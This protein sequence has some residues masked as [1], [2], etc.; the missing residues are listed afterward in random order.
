M[1]L[2]AAPLRMAIMPPPGIASATPVHVVQQSPVQE[3][4]PGWIY[5]PPQAPQPAESTRY[6][7]ESATYP[8]AY[9]TNYVV[10]KVT[11][12][13]GQVPQPTYYGL[14]D[15]DRMRH[16]LGGQSGTPTEDRRMARIL[17]LPRGEVRDK[18]M[19]GLIEAHVESNRRNTNPPFS[20]RNLNEREG[21]TLIPRNGT[22]CT[23][24][25]I[26]IDTGCAAPAIITASLMRRMGLEPALQR[27]SA[28]YSAL[29]NSGEF[30][31]ELPAGELMLALALG[32]PG[33][34]KLH[35]AWLVIESNT[36]TY[37]CLIGTPVITSLNLRVGPWEQL[38]FYQRHPWD[39][40][41]YHVPVITTLAPGRL[42][43]VLHLTATPTTDFEVYSVVMAGAAIGEARTPDVVVVSP[44][45]AMDGPYHPTWYPEGE[46]TE[47]W[48]DIPLLVEGADGEHVS[49]LT[50]LT[51]GLRA[52]T[53]QP[54]GLPGT[55]LTAAQQAVAD[56]AA[57]QTV[58]ELYAEDRVVP[59]PLPFDMYA[60]YMRG[61]EGEG[62]ALAMHMPVG[63]GPWETCDAEVPIVVTTPG[64][65]G[66]VIMGGT[67]LRLAASVLV[68]Q[69]DTGGTST[70]AQ[71][72]VGHPPAEVCPPLESAYWAMRRITAPDSQRSAEQQ[73]RNVEMQ[74]AQFAAYEQM[75]EE[76][77]DPDTRA[78][79]AEEQHMRQAE[80]P[81]SWEHTWL[82]REAEAKQLAAVLPAGD[83]EYIKSRKQLQDKAGEGNGNWD[84]ED[85]FMVHERAWV[86]KQHPEVSSPMVHSVAEYRY[87]S[88]IG[89]YSIRSS[90]AA[91]MGHEAKGAGPSE[92]HEQGSGGTV[93]ETPEAER[94]GSGSSSELE[95]SPSAEERAHRLRVVWDM[96]K[97]DEEKRAM[98]DA[99]DRTRERAGECAFG[100]SSPGA[101]IAQGC[102]WEIAKRQVLQEQPDLEQ[103]AA[104]EKTAIMGRVRAMLDAGVPGDRFLGWHNGKELQEVRY[105]VPGLKGKQLVRAGACWILSRQRTRDELEA[106]EYF[107]TAWAKL[108]ATRKQ[109][110]AAGPSSPSTVEPGGHQAPAVSRTPAADSQQHVQ[111][112][113]QHRPAGL[114]QQPEK[115]TA[116]QRTAGQEAES[117]RQP[118]AAEHTASAWRGPENQAWR[119]RNHAAADQ[120][121]T[122]QQKT[123]LE[124]C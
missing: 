89:G 58:A 35:V 62:A 70:A 29:A 86:R 109:R 83:A 44:V 76:G 67:Q 32:A 104:A 28:R 23:P 112:P 33:Q 20:F 101:R 46:E 21:C 66:E 77:D 116:K 96:Q 31:G 114:Q 119:E 117:Q 4:H 91:K 64:G 124:K 115:P 92:P 84:E 90:P 5:G 113:G 111:Q 99:E 50:V 100:P 105:L 75:A 61:A 41:F 79:L 81:G 60:D 6:Y 106:R 82:E 36:L 72:A 19:K 103:H 98:R 1:Q 85:E 34:V 56:E 7:P 54:Q 13:P 123:S 69:I 110:E 97:R 107:M 95:L 55:P 74:A 42:P 47:Q 118:G 45:G 22:P 16:A 18:E 49:N 102:V 8:E 37:T 15:L 52:S 2:Q 9:A 14:E 40:G 122:E 10:L 11:E 12:E 43:T 94:G 57:I 17:G 78:G 68:G 71:Q 25:G 30:L 63:L 53:G 24:P 121:L 120:S 48:K 80:E 59:P 3:A 65:L 73:A 87:D 38:G 27:T 39:R 51:L 93:Q 108:E 88:M 26:V